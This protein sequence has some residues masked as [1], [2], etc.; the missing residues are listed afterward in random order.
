M[1]SISLF[2]ALA[3]INAF[4]DTYVNFVRQNQQG[5]GVVWDM[6][7]AATGT[8]PSALSIDTGGSLFQLWTINQTTPKDYLL[9][10]KLVG[11]YLPKAD[12]KITTLDPYAPYPRTRV[13]QPFTVQVNV[14]GLLTGSGLPDASTKVLLEQ[15]IQSYPAGVNS[16][17]PTAVQSNTPLTTGFLTNNGPT[18]LKFPASSLKAGDS[19]KA[20]GEEH[21]VVHALSDGT[22]TQTQIAS[23]YVQVLPIASG[24]ILGIKPGEELRYQIPTVQLNLNDLYP[25][26]DTYLILYE[27]TGANGTPGTVAASFPMDRDRTDSQILM[28]TDLATK[29]TKDGT[30]TLALMSS[31]VY[32]TELLCDTVTFSVKRSIS[33][34][35]MQVNYSDGNSN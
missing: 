14:A 21:F 35:A 18:V 8:A 33:V 2:L 20:T 13:D 26:S 23:A 17:A 5:T 6:P 29:F 22:I 30:Y 15:H 1:K 7:V 19:T 27:G 11:A 16:L 31:T 24:Q 28:V 34:N 10:Q 12:I 25:R 32:G 9:D 4:A 3:S